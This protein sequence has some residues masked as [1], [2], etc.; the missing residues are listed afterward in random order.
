MLLS[1]DLHVGSMLFKMELS[2]HLLLSFLIA[3]ICGETFPGISLI[4]AI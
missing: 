2:M 4:R 3:T 1:T